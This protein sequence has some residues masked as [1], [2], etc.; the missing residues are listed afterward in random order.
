MATSLHSGHCVRRVTFGFPAGLRAST[1]MG[2]TSRRRRSR[3]FLVAWTRICP[4]ATRVPT[5][6]GIHLAVRALPASTSKSLQAEDAG[7]G[8]K[9]RSEVELNHDRP[10]LQPHSS[11]ASNR[12]SWGVHRRTGITRSENH[13]IRSESRSQA[14]RDF[15]RPYTRGVAENYWSGRIC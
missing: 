15:R 10:I 1:R 9:S 14:Q 6:A 13:E 12:V 4:N 8:L 7:S 3:S 5:T 2:I 11:A